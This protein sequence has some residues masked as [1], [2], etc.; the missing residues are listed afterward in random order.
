MGPSNGRQPDVEDIDGDD[1][2][3]EYPDN[4]PDEL[5]IELPVILFT[6]SVP[7]GEYRVDHIENVEKGLRTCAGGLGLRGLSSIRD[8]YTTG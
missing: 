3:S 6:I 1:E 5:L 7:P 4:L 8:R 2:S